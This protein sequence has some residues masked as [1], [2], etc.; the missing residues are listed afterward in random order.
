[1][2]HPPTNVARLAPDISR[3]NMFHQNCRFK[4]F[5]NHLEPQIEAE[6]R[7]GTARQFSFQ[8][9]VS[10]HLNDM[11]CSSSRRHKDLRLSARLLTTSESAV[12]YSC[13][14]SC[15]HPVGLPLPIAKS[16]MRNQRGGTARTR[17]SRVAVTEL[18]NKCGVEEYKT[19]GS[20]Q[21]FM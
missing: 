3:L 14:H 2:H 20:R 9:A 12:Y 19:V 16:A 15:T 13:L 5:K 6:Q 8:V 17:R 7:P 18:E 1:M 11:V 21:L 10:N 4:Y